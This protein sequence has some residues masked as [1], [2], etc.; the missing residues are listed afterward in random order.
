LAKHLS[1]FLLNLYL[2]V[3]K[4]PPWLNLHLLTKSSYSLAKPLFIGKKFIFFG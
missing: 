2:L 4:I 3:K 1:L